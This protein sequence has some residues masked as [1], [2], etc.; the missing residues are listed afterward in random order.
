MMTVWMALRA[1]PMPASAALDRSE[2]GEGEQSDD[3]GGF[4]GSGEVSA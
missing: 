4:E 2:E 3:D 1:M